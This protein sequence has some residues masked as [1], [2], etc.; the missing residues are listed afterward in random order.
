MQEAEYYAGLP[1]DDPRREYMQPGRG[2]PSDREQRVQMMVDNGT[3]PEIATGIATGQFVVRTNPYSQQPEVVNLADG[4]VVF[5]GNTQT[6]APAASQGDPGASA[7]DPAAPAAEQGRPSYIPESVDPTDATGASGFVG[8]LVNQVSDLFGQGVPF[9]E[10]EEAAEALNTT[11]ILTMSLL[12]A[13]IPGRPSQFLLQKLEK[14]T[15]D[16]K[17]LARADERSITRLKQTRDLI[18]H[19]VDRVERDILARPQDFKPA[20]MTKARLNSSQLKSLLKAYDAMLGTVA[21]R[22]DESQPGLEQF[23]KRRR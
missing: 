13:E 10:I 6:G 15:V 2:K 7:P 22:R 23:D 19:E 9:P 14:L 16:A 20:D 21:T 8:G 18:K 17:S 5:D 3:P 12:Q 11:Q 1:E 4:R